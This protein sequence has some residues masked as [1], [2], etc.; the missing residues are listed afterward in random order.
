M[1]SWHATANS[2]IDG[3]QALLPAPPPVGPARVVLV[4]ASGGGEGAT[5]LAAH[6]AASLARSG[7]RTLLIDANLRRPSL[8]AAFR[9]PPGPGL[10][11]VLRGEAAVASVVRAAPPE[12]LWLLPAGGCDLRAVQ[13]MA[14]EGTLA[15]L[16]QLRR[17]YE[18]IVIDAC[19]VLPAPDALPLVRR[20]DAVILS[21]RAGASRMAAVHAGW[22]RLTAAGARLMGTVV[23]GAEDDPAALVSYPT[24]PAQARP[25]R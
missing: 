19:P 3:L 21:V 1:K 9:V 7:R 18:H 2:A 12:R 22:Q 6:L 17:D 10:S 25:A 14:R 4:T 23:H 5:T 20:S 16:D 8:H 15:F 24:P 13:A 11:E